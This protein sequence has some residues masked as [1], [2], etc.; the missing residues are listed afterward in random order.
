MLGFILVF[1]KEL[2]IFCAVSPENC[3]SLRQSELTKF[4]LFILIW[5][6]GFQRLFSRYEKSDKRESREA[7]RKTSGTGR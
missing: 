6:P 3:I 5:Y 4:F 7:A 1:A 2:L